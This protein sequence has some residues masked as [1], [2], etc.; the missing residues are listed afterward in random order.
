MRAGEAKNNNNKCNGKL[1]KILEKCQSRKINQPGKN[2][3][4]ADFPSLACS[5]DIFFGRANVLLAKAHVETRKEG[6]KWGE[7][8]GA[9]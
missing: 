8:K 1:T 4:P 5:A 9:G 7:S 3:C 2:P 6:R